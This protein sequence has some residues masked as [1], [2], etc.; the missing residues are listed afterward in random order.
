MVTGACNEPEIQTAF[1]F[2]LKQSQ[3]SDRQ[4]CKRVM[5]VDKSDAALVINKSFLE[6]DL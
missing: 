4:P 3:E 1:S 2:I 6:S 5:A